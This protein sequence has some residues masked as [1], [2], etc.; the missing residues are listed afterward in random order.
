[1][2]PD[3]AHLRKM[4]LPVITLLVGAAGWFW[5]QT[6]NETE[7]AISKPSFEMSVAPEAVVTVYVSGKV[8][9]P[10]VIELEL[11]SRVI[12]AINAAGGMIIKNPNLN[13][14]R[15]LVD[16]EQIV[17]AKASSGNS[18]QSGK[19]N[20]NT[21]D[22]TELETIPGIGPVMAIRIIDFRT[23]KGRFQSINDLDQ[24]AGIG[25]SLMSQ[26]QE[27]AVVE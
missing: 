9:K 14:A 23:S 4:Q 25:P 2:F 20:L 13:L 18:L 6:P 26:F 1:M 21:A 5:L 16:G 17:V 22:Q 19:I 24:I 11:G 12:D 7:I 15:V 27:L 8:A 10:G 3:L